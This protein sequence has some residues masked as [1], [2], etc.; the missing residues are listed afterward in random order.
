MRFSVILGSKIE[1]EWDPH[2]NQNLWKNPKLGFL[3]VKTKFLGINNPP[4]AID[5]NEIAQINEKS[6]IRKSSKNEILKI[7]YIAPRDRAGQ[8]TYTPTFKKC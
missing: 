6:K 4:P 1:T 7:G 3:R 2:R 5:N 8:T